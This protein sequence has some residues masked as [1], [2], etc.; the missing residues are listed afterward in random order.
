LNG[1]EVAI[2]NHIAKKRINESNQGVERGNKMT[3]YRPLKK[4]VLEDV[5]WQE[6]DRCGKM[7]LALPLTKSIIYLCPACLIERIKA[8]RLGQVC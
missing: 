5:R 2:K 4:M 3:A 6:C 7:F 8:R 1:G